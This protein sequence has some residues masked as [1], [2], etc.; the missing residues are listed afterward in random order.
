MLVE[1]VSVPEPCGALSTLIDGEAASAVYEPPPVE[2]C[3]PFHDCEPAVEVAVPFVYV[4]VPVAPPAIVSESTVMVWPET[5]TVPL[6]EVTWPA[7][8]ASCGVVQP[9]GTTI[10]TPPFVIPPVAAV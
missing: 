7:P 5:E 9:A 4:I 2:R 1:V 6:L 10:L 8:A 3:C